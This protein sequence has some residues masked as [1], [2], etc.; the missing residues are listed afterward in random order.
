MLLLG[1]EDAVTRALVEAFRG[2]I[3]QLGWVVGRSL[4]LG[5]CW[6]ADDVRKC[7]AELVRS[8]PDVIVVQGTL[9]TEAVLLETRTIPTVF[10][11]VTDPAAAGFVA[12]LSR[13]G[14]N[15][16]G[17]ANAA[18]SIAGDRLHVLKDIAPD[19]AH[20]LLIHD[21]NY[22]TPPGLLRAAEAAAVT[23]G[24]QLAAS[25]AGD[26]AELEDQIHNLA[27]A[28][29]GGLVVLPSPLTGANGQFI[30]GLAARHH[31]PA[32]YPLPNYAA[33][34]GMISYGVNTPVLWREAATY[35]DR[36]LRGANAGELPVHEPG[37]DIVV[38][39]KTAKALGFVIPPALLTRATEV[40]E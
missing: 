16:T 34:G 7:A 6:A 39:L 28:S 31:L 3:E 20:V 24:L 29:N 23:L 36:I 13:P 9:G 14:G 32:I 11:Q 4:Q 21:R 2:R 38:N 8:A 26:A 15:V 35:V 27:R 10:V 17:I 30:I 37:V 5:V 22:P 19:V 1:V 33:A 12:S 25:G 18:S 40:I